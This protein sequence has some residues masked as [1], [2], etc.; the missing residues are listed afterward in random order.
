MPTYTS[1]T[2]DAIANY[3]LGKCAEAFALHHLDGEGA[4]TV[5]TY[6]GL[7]TRQADAAINAGEEMFRKE[8]QIETDCLTCSVDF[9]RYV[10]ANRA[11][12]G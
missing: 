12:F 4:S 3:G 2:R 6:L 10:R 1:K 8:W 5:G 9:K 11:L 7:K